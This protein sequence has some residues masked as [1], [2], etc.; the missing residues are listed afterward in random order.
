[1]TGALVLLLAASRGSA[2][3]YSDV[4]NT[5]DQPFGSASLRGPFP[6][7]PAGFGRVGNRDCRTVMEPI[8]STSG[9]TIRAACVY[10][11][12]TCFSTQYV[13]FLE[14][15]R[16]ANVYGFS[17]EAVSGFT[18]LDGGCCTPDGTDW[19]GA[20]GMPAGCT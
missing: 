7:L 11:G 20:W 8:V 16:A 19:C 1:M 2:Q 5:C 17:M 10:A 4:C 9:I 12:D 6:C 18:G 13:S 14:V 15:F 3:Q